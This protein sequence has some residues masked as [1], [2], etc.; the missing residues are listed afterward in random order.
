MAN[1]HPSNKDLLD[2][3]EE[4]R[5]RINSQR[6]SKGKYPQGDQVLP[7]VF[8]MF[9][10]AHS[11]ME[12]FTTTDT[13]CHFFALRR[14]L[15]TL[16]EV[17]MFTFFLSTNGKISQ[18]APPRHFDASYRMNERKLDTP[19]PFILLGFDQLMKSR[20][21]FDRYK[22]LGDVTSLD[23]IAHMGRPL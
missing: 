20:K 5:D 13:R 3:F 6:V 10:E 7:D 23:C 2:T 18:F 9:D 1:D 17:P 21:I 14:V 15:Q 8:I 11:L 16:Y 12:P 22:T 4:L 19:R